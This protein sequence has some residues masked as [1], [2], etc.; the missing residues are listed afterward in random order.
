MKIPFDTTLSEQDAV[1]SVHAR[2]EADVQACIANFFNGDTEAGA[3]MLGAQVRLEKARKTWLR[4]CL[5]KYSKPAVPGFI[6]LQKI[7]QTPE[8]GAEVEEADK[9]GH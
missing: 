3:K 8:A 7:D 9:Q 4:F 5:V 1:F 6:E 2:A